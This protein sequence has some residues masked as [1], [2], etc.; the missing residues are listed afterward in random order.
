MT[1]SDNLH[2]TSIQGPDKFH[3]TSIT[4]SDKKESEHCQE[5]PQSLIAE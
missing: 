5:I 1:N 3:V 4:D 2:V